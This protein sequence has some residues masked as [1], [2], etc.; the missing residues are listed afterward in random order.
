MGVLATKSSVGSLST[1]YHIANTAYF[2]TSI[3]S[4]ISTWFATVL[5]L[6]YSY[7]TKLGRAKYWVIVSIPLVY[8]L[9][10]FQTQLID[11]F[12]PFRLS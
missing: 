4:F 11:L 9:S 12:T 8:F 6:Q 2:I 3:L 7:S 10:Q 5:L 1:G